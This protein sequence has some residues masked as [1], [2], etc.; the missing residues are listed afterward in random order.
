MCESTERE[1]RKGA[2]SGKTLLE[3]V[4]VRVTCDVTEKIR[5]KYRSKNKESEVLF[6]VSSSPKRRKKEVFWCLSPLVGKHFVIWKLN[7]GAFNKSFSRGVPTVKG[8]RKPL[9][10]PNVKNTH[11][12][13]YLLTERE[14]L[15]F[16]DIF[17]S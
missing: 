4:F 17:F 8:V 7:S 9:L 10:F 15:F 6:C 16:N 2:L 14:Y 3:F 1:H 11:T 13:T 5:K 12:R